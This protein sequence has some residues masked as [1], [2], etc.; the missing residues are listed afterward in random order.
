MAK[1]LLVGLSDEDMEILDK[2]SKKQG[3]RKSEYIRALIQSLWIAET[4]KENEKGNYTF[5]IGGYGYVLEK[6]FMEGFVKGLEPLF[7]DIEKQLNRAKIKV[8]KTDRRVLIRNA[9]K[10]KKVA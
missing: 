8:K 5:E 6:D 2:L 1:N 10:Y 3:L 7:Q 9:M 4:L